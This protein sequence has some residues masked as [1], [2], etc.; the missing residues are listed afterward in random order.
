LNYELEIG[1]A[2]GSI[3][4]AIIFIILGQYV[5]PRVKPITEDRWDSP[6]VSKLINLFKRDSK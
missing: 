3:T 4:T 2:I 1:I 6:L 5:R